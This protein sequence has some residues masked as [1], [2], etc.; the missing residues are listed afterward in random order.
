MKIKTRR[1]NLLRRR[2]KCLVRNV[3]S[4]APR[5]SL[6]RAALKF[7]WNIGGSKAMNVKRISFLRW[8]KFLLP[9]YEDLEKQKIV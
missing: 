7:V 2:K 1:L 9:K 8:S 6:R 3:N 5:N 4:S